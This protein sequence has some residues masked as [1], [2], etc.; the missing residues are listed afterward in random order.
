[1]FLLYTNRKPKKLYKPIEM[2]LTMSD[3]NRGLANKGWEP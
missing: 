2:N 1:M 3:I